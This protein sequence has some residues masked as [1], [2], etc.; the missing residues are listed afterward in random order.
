MQIKKF[1]IYYLCNLLSL[2]PNEYQKYIYQK[3]N[4]HNEN[5]NFN[6]DENSVWIG[7]IIKNSTL[8]NKLLPD[9][10]ELSPIS[11]YKYEKTQN[12]V[13][14]FN[15]FHVNSEYFNGHRL[16]IVT[17]AKD[18]FTN[19]KRFV[20]LDYYSDTISIDPKHIFKTPNALK[21]NL[22][23]NHKNMINAYSDENYLIS[24]EKNIKYYFN[25]SNEFAIDCNKNIYY[26]L[27]DNHLPN[28]LSFDES[29]I[30]IV[31]KANINFIYNN[32]WIESRYTSP[33]YSFYY[34]HETKFKI[35]SEKLSNET[36]YINNYEIND[37][38][39]FNDY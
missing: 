10:L 29:K 6:V 16:E 2:L 1:F 17:V 30:G 5:I 4:L 21:M 8:I 31:K 18:I 22:Y 19:K 34:P 32:L 3:S 39:V 11:V 37:F 36:N 24:V 35:I 7:Y 38:I 12:F 26:G 15:F 33:I 27:N 13:L 14:F 25:L 9:N 23:S 20:I 28:F